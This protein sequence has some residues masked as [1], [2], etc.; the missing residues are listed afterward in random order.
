MSEK[1]VECFEEC[2]DCM[3]ASC[4]YNA[5]CHA[6][7]LCNHYQRNPTYGEDECPHDWEEE[8]SRQ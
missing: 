1:V 4:D 2:E 7:A 5:K 6:C 3:C 8:R